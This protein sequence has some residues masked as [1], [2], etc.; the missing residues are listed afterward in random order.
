MRHPGVAVTPV[1]LITLVGGAVFTSGRVSTQA[2]GR[3][4]KA[5]AD[6][7]AQTKP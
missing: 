2:L 3:G 1:G 7:A 6:R 4:R 5:C